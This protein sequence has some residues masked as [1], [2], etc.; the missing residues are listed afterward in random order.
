MIALGLAFVLA[1]APAPAL[2][3]RLSEDQTAFEVVG[4]ERTLLAKLKDEPPA[5]WP[6]VFR[7]VVKNDS[8]SENIPPLLGTYSVTATGVRF[9]PRFPPQPGIS[10]R[11]SF[12]FKDAAINS[13][14]T[15]PK[16]DGAPKTAITAVYP[17]VDI[18]PENLVR[19]YIHFNGPMNHKDIYRHLKLIRDDGKPVDMPFLEIDEQLWS[20]DGTRLTIWCDPGRVKR[21]LVPRLEAGPV[22]EEGRRYTFIIDRNWEDADGRPLKQEFRK[23]FAVGPPDDSPVDPAMWSLIPPWPSKDGTSSLI[24]RLAKPHDRALLAR[25]LWITDAAGKKVE[26]TITVGGGERVVTF[27][28]AKPWTNGTYNLVIDTRL[29]DICG[30]RVGQ[31]FEVDEFKPIERKI[32]AKTV[33]RPFVV[34]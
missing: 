20:A 16:L 28:P 33:S 31:P 27:A 29:E 8:D 22:L 14:I 9:E 26:G 13:V 34:K 17:S 25:M 12:H 21:N 3:L 32:E 18:L 15:V 4:L 24:V 6:A 11:A 7:V 5:R 30:N 23:T 10:Y 1:A 2:T 19:F